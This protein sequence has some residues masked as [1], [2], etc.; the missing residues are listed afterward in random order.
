MA[1]RAETVITLLEDL[2][3]AKL[4]ESWDNSGLQVGNP[5]WPV[6][7][8]LLT[9]DVTSEVIDHAIS[10][11]F[12]FILAHHPLIFSKLS[13]IDASTPLG[14]SIAR[15]LANEICIYALHTNLD[16]I[17]GG[18]SDALVAT[19]SLKGVQ[20]LDR[21]SPGYCKLVLY[22]PENYLYPIRR[23]LEDAGTERVSNY[24][25]CA[26]AVDSPSQSI[27]GEGTRLSSDKILPKAAECRLEAVILRSRLAPVLRAVKEAYPYKE[28]A[29]DIIPLE[30]KANWGLGR[31]GLLPRPMILVDFAVHLGKLLAC[32][33]LKICGK[34]ERL[35]RK[36]AVCGGSGGKLIPLAQFQGADVLVTGDID[37]HDALAAAELGLA[38]VDPGHYS[39]E[40]PILPV[41]KEYLEEKLPELLVAVFPNSTDPMWFKAIHSGWE[42]RE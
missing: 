13:R 16:V 33:H 36:V 17:Q 31:I 34:P 39:S 7:K 10:E 41:L 5:H 1:V 28:V 22:V 42:G 27:P 2:A 19:L 40:H 18:V 14:L 24:P 25:H 6:D 26:F 37:H 11:G 12:G 20:V 23:V 3:P 21:A 35:L 9:L 38:L 32:S 15:A 29:Y 8:V 4:Q 30:N